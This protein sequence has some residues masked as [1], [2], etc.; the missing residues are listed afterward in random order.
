MGGVRVAADLG[1][2]CTFTEAAWGQ[3]GIFAQFLSG[4]RKRLTQNKKKKR[5]KQAARK[6][7]KAF[8][9]T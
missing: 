8:S 3:R 7:G 6:A 4:Y 2:G 9:Y 5:E 1:F